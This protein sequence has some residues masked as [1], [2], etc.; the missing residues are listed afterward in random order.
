VIFR[1]DGDHGVQWADFDL[2]GALDLA[3]A[4]N[5]PMGSHYL[6]HSQLPADRARRS[7]QVLVLD[8]KGHYTKAGSEVRLYAAGTRRLIGTN[9][10]D[11]GSGYCSQSAMPVHFG[12]GSYDGAVD[13]EVTHF[14]PTGRLVTRMTGVEPRAY[15]GKY[16]EVRVGAS[17]GTRPSA[18]GRFPAAAF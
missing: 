10:V 5:E 16:L 14:T 6:F 7:L 2:D 13:V 12:L 9:I 8:I 11:T 17:S 4:N 1:H 15:Q 3:L 18:G